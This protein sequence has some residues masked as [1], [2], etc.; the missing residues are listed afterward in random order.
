MKINI[1][2][3]GAGFIGTNLTL[4]LLKDDN[5]IVII[6]D[7]L[8]SGRTENIEQIN[9]DRCIA[10][11]C[12]IAN[13]SMVDTLFKH[14]ILPL[15]KKEDECVIYNLACPASP[16]FYQED[17]IQT[18]KTCVY[19]S[20]N[21]LEIARTYGY[22]VLFTS[23]SEVYGDPMEHPQKEEYRGNVSC[24]GI[25]SCYDEGKRCAE[26][27]HFDY[28]R[29]YN[30]DVKVVRLFNTYGPYMRPDDGRFISNFINQALENKPI[31]IYGGGTQTRSICFVD[32]TVAGLIKMMDSSE[33]G[34]IN[35]GNPEEKTVNEWAIEIDNIIHPDNAVF[36]IETKPLPGD[37]PLQ[38]KPDIAKA[39]KLLDW[40]PKV[41]Y[42]IGLSKT[43]DYYRNVAKK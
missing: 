8:S 42:T 39:K 23:T 24:T 9:N 34:P 6:L 12:D 15:I 35:I 19:G 4:E 26:S 17:P 43:I 1:I 5:N 27:I 28:M 37:D 21:I 18:T 40:E 22:K 2:A 38:R 32:D 29:Q 33:H 7:N 41:N 25:R 36:Q 14:K 16:P 20:I 10:Y 30:V 3:G 13:K 31:T 11:I